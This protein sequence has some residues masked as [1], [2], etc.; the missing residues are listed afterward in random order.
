MWVTYKHMYK[1]T[2]WPLFDVHH[3]C[4]RYVYTPLLLY[5]LVS[6]SLSKGHAVPT[7][8][9]IQSQLPFCLCPMLNAII[10]FSDYFQ[11][12]QFL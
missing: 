11:L 3:C 9:F 4:A 8:L 1:V 7:V 2:V 6:K 10:Y 5:H 12:H